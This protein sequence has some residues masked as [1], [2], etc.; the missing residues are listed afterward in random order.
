MLTD[1]QRRVIR[2]LC[3]RTEPALVHAGTARVLK[4]A[5]LIERYET[6]GLTDWWIIT[7]AGRRTLEDGDAK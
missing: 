4:N 5:G 2:T 3:A 6:S 7:P 1:A